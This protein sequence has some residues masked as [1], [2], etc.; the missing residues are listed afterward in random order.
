MRG[1]EACANA[2]IWDGITGKKLGLPFGHVQITKTY[3]KPDIPY[4]KNKPETWI[5]L[6]TKHYDYN[7]LKF[8]KK[9][10]KKYLKAGY[11]FKLQF[12]S[13]RCVVTKSGGIRKVPGDIEYLESTGKRVP[14]APHLLSVKVISNIEAC[15]RID[16]FRR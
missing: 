8:K 11:P 7:F 1:V 4:D 3:N 9:I 12:D 14:Y 5:Q 13:G 10:P 16:R 15:E 6:M 2:E